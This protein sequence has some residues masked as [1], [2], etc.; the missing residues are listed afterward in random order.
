MMTSTRKRIE[1]LVMEMQSAFLD[2]PM[3][4]LTLPA[5]RRRFGGDEITCAGVLG[6]LLD[7]RVLTEREGVYRRNFPRPAARSAA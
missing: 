5:A 4:C 1:S 6:A 2:H 3:L 7:A